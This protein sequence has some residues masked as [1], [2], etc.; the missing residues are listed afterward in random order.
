MLS[1]VGLVTLMLFVRFSLTLS[2]GFVGLDALRL[3]FGG[4]LVYNL[5]AGVLCF[6]CL[7][8]D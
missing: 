5:L 3:Q 7:V 1:S 2:E 6:Y 8:C 4:S